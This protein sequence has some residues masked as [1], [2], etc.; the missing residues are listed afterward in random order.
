MKISFY[1]YLS[2]FLSTTAWSSNFQECKFEVKVLS[3]NVENSQLRLLKV[4]GDDFKIKSCEHFLGVVNISKISIKDGHSLVKSGSSLIA[5]RS[6][7]SGM[8]PQG[9]VSSFSWSFQAVK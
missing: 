8:G 6:S 4:V 2:L 1:F 3:I 9:H 5:K 7:Y